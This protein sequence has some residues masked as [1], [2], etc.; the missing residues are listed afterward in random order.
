MAIGALWL[1]LAGCA[2]RGVPEPAYEGPVRRFAVVAINDVYRIDGLSG[3]DLGGLARVR[4]LRAQLEDEG[5]EVLL[6]HAG[7]MLSP[8]LLGRSFRGAQMIDVL[9]GLDGDFGAFDPK[10][11]ATF[12][13]H[14]FDLGAG[15]LSE[16]LRESGFR[17]LSSNVRFAEGDDGAPLVDAGTLV[18]SAIVEVGGVRVGLLGITTGVKRPDYVA[19]IDTD[20]G[21]VARFYSRA[22]RRAGADRVIAVT[23]L[24]AEDDA[25]LLGLD[26]G[27]DLLVGGHDH[28][29]MQRVVNG[30][31]MIKADA[32][33]ASAAVL[34]LT[35]G[36]DGELAVAHRWVD[37]DATVPRDPAVQARVDGWEARFEETY[38]PEIGAEAGCLDAPLGTAGVELIARESAIRRYETNLGDLVADTA[39][40]ALADRG[41]QVAFINS[42][43][44]RLNEDIPAGAT[45]ARR[46]VEELLPY[47]TP[48]RLIAIDGATLQAVVERSV[49]D[50]TGSGHWLQVAGLAFVHDPEAGT[51]SQLSLL[52]ADGPRPVVPD[53]EIL[54]VT[55]HYLLEPAWGDQDGYTMLDKGM[56][57]AEGP[58]LKAA[59]VE[60]FRGEVAPIVEGRI[61]NTER[62]GPCLIE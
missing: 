10:L 17:W 3:V 59:L 34:K 42:G 45:L 56:I 1:L 5:Y 54:A 51:A 15:E 23:H 4:T 21:R 29:R 9:G 18:R 8:S 62:G 33:A 46:Q 14:E 6:L 13:N 32:D 31:L 50:W 28:V 47:S 48:L 12:G 20:Y 52:T 41:A 37:L 25:A 16:R 24:D 43:A 22:L 36:S 7:D 26:G 61:C 53:E 38:C 55:S 2:G 35:L 44:I 49:A 19:S 30:R 57:R 39:L 11:F 40:T 58:D 60:A 27:P